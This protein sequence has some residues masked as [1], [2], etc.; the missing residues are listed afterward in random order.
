M[1]KDNSVQAAVSKYSSEPPVG[2][3]SIEVG[4]QTY[5]I[6]R[7]R[8]GG[9]ILKLYLVKDGSTMIELNRGTV[10]DTQKEI[11]NRL[12]M[13]QSGIKMVSYFSTNEAW[14]FSDLGSSDRQ[15]L[16]GRLI[17]VSVLDSIREKSKEEMEE[18]KGLDRDISGQVS[19]LERVKGRISW[20]D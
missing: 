2:S 1:T 3:V 18:S 9:P 13:D 14:S 15:D 19:A 17:G 8:S 12:G 5:F 11:Y 7:S 16:M 20:I 4:D 6:S 10:K